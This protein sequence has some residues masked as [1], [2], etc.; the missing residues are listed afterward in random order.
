M[1]KVIINCLVHFLQLDVLS[2]RLTMELHL[3]DLH[4]QY[5]ESGLCWCIVVCNLINHVAEEL[6]VQCPKIPKFKSEKIWCLM[7]L[8]TIF[9]LINK[10]QIKVNKKKLLHINMLLYLYSTKKYPWCMKVCH[11]NASWIFSIII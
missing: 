6:V 1:Q 9:Q 2:N 10:F 3:N 4:Q 8:S 5:D 11:R 7:S